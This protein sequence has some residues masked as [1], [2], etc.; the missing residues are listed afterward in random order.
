MF[1]HRALGWRLDQRTKFHGGPFSTSL[2][3]P[4]A[5]IAFAHSALLSRSV[6]PN[7]Y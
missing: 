5:A 1:V 7:A 3:H 2:T 4:I 6:Y